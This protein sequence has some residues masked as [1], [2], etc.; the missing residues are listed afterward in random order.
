MF[1]LARKRQ[2]RDI[3]RLHLT[4]LYDNPRVYWTRR[5]VKFDNREHEAYV[6][7][8]V[9]AYWPHP[10]VTGYDVDPNLR[11]DATLAIGGETFHVELDAETMARKKVVARLGVYKDCPDNLLIVT[12]S[13][14]RM[15]RLMGWCKGLDAAFFSTIQQVIQNPFGSI[16]LD[17]GGQKFAINKPAAAGPAAGR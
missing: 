3:G 10:A 9:L 12:L 7:E 14:A 5:P 1:K 16:W 11:P 17:A 4:A 8:V 15:R 6:M 2:V 13:E